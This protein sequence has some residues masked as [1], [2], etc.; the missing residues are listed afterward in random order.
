MSNNFCPITILASDR[1]ININLDVKEVGYVES[2]KVIQETPKIQIN[3]SKVKQK[4]AIIG[5]LFLLPEMI[6]LALLYVFPLIFSLI[7]SF[8]QWNLL[9]G[10]SG[11]EFVGLDNFKQ[12]FQDEKVLIAIKNNLQF[13]FMVVPISMAISLV[14]AVVIHSNVYLQ[15]YFKVAF[16]IPYISSIIAVGAVWRALYHPSA[17]PINQF[18]MSIGIAD[19]PKWLADTSASL[20]AIIIITIWTLIGYVVVIYI[21]GLSNIPPSLYEAASIDGASNFQKFYKITLPLLGPTHM[22]LAITLLI[23][24]FKVFDLIAFLTDGG[25]INSSTVLVYLIYEE[26]FQKY[27]MGYASALSW[28]LFAIVSVLTFLTW[29]VQNN[30]MFN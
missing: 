16:F 29:K 18:L 1:I 28:L 19:P 8:S 27:N 6:G 15:S 20:L 22:F 7:L 11:I 21:A 10:L 5:W 2:G 4:E 23:G 17:G 9:G 14:L 3:R 30:K 24:S 13:T 12:M 25:P 26:G